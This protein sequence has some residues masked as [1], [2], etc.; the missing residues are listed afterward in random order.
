M[1]SAIITTQFQASFTF[2]PQSSRF[3]ADLSGHTS[4]I[5]RIASSSSLLAETR[6]RI[7]IAP[8]SLADALA[9]SNSFDLAGNTKGFKLWFG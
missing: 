9:L 5:L 1:C 8:T 3:A 7:A 6:S 4:L 2:L